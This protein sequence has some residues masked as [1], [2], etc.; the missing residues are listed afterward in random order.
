VRTPAR[1]RV[2]FTWDDERHINCLG[3]RYPADHKQKSHERILSA[4]ADLFRRR[5]IAAT[6]V[7]SV[8]AAAGLTAGGFYGHFP[9]KAAL[10]A[11]AVSKAGQK[12]HARWIVP[13]DGLRGRAWSR[14]FVRRYLSEE[15]RDD[16][17]SGCSLPSLAADVARSGVPARRQLELRLAGLFAL[18]GERTGARTA[19]EREQAIAAVALCVGGLV[20]SRAVVAQGL[21]REILAACR[22]GA[23]RLLEPQPAKS[24][25]TARKTR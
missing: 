25:R 14:A 20:L 15:H 10:V 4:A 11:A 5:G 2:H 17:V 6:G 1:T 23:E 24:P 13:F 19:H 22:A 9:S 3:V 8:M 12:A 16:R 21:S 7:D 18:I